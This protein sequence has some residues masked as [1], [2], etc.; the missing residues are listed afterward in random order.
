MGHGH[1]IP[2]PDGSRARCGGPRACRQCALEL[3]NAPADEATS[4]IDVDLAE[5]LEAA[6]WNFD[7]RRA[8][9]NR[10]APQAERDAFKA[11]VRELLAKHGRS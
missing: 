4:M 7:A 11:A 6:Y 2:N 10:F 9:L 3:A 5:A 1:V 8:G